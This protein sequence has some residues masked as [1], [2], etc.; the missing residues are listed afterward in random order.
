MLIKQPH[1]ALAPETKI[2]DAALDQDLAD[3]TAAGIPHVQPVPTPGVHVA[4]D[5]ALDPVRRA[6]IRHGEDAAIDQEGRVVDDDDVEGVNGRG[7]RRVRGAV[8][9]DVIRVGDVDG[10]FG[11]GKGDAVRSAEAVGHDADVAGR[12]VETVHLLRELGFRSEALLVAVDGVGEPD[13]AVGVDDDV[14]GRIEGAAVVV[15]D[16]GGGFVRPFGFHVDEPGRFVQG[17]LG[18]EEDAV[19]VVGAAVGH[20]VALGA[21]D[22]VAREVG[23]AGEFDLGDD[24]GFVGGAD[25]SGV[26]VADLVGG[27]EE[28][29]GGGVEDAGFV[30]EGGAV[31]FDQ[32]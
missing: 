12:R 1:L 13:C 8:A 2:R 25:G 24:D 7:A 18:A 16:Q 3:Q 14:V 29:V 23:R 28:G 6:R 9:V 27:D 21:A 32:E 26:F 5:V 10:V 22:F 15:V 30:E 20:V 31:V 4:V 19:L 11:G 17:A